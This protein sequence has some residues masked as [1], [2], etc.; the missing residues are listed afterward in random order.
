MLCCGWCL[1]KSLLK[2][3]LWIKWGLSWFSGLAPY[4]VMALL[5]FSDMSSIIEN[6]HNNIKAMIISLFISH[7]YVVCTPWKMY[8]NK[9]MAWST[10]IKLTIFCSCVRNVVFKSNR[11][12][13]ASSICDYPSGCAPPI[14]LHRSSKPESYSSFFY[15]LYSEIR[16][17]Q[18]T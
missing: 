11:P 2:L 16:T 15:E 7:T 6:T 17:E 9:L 5:T 4:S 1:F 8:S 18:Y 10:S 14:S 3:W 12:I 13:F